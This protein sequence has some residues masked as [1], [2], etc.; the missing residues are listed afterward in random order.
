MVRTLAPI[1]LTTHVRPGVEV[2][3]P[4]TLG[5]HEERSASTADDFTAGLEDYLVVLHALLE[6]LDLGGDAGALFALLLGD[7]EV[8][9]DVTAV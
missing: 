8:A 4:E 7:R 6:I 5:C 1:P 9:E 3:I 2:C